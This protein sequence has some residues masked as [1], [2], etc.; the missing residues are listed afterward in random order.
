MVRVK[1]SRPEPVADFRAARWM[2]LVKRMRREQRLRILVTLLETR[3][4]PAASP[5]ARAPD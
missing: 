2:K 3:T 4:L 5:A 1:Q